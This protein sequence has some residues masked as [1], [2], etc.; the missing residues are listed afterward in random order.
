MVWGSEW[1]SHTL[2]LK[3]PPRTDTLIFCR[4]HTCRRL[5]QLQQLDVSGFELK[6]GAK[7]ALDPTRLSV[8]LCE[9]INMHGAV[10]VLYLLLIALM[11]N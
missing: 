7:K 3:S 6:L 2:A 4:R 10:K 5:Q 9:V 1:G 11:L 8:D